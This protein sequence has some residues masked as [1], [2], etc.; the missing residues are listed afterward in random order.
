MNSPRANLV[1]PVRTSVVVRVAQEWAFATFGEGLSHWWP[2]GSHRI[3]ATSAAGVVLEPGVG[4]RLYER[5]VDGSECDWG[6]VLVWEPPSRLVL[7]WQIDERWAPAP[8]VASEVEVRFLAL[9]PEVTRVALEHRGLEVFGAS[10]RAMR[11]TFDGE[12]G[13]SMLLSRYA[14]H[15]GAD[16]SAPATPPR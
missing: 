16:T 6:R 1:E 13:W 9:S 7:S 2:L 11:G 10:A 4:G 15:A 12:G 14:A 8:E 3:G 5:G